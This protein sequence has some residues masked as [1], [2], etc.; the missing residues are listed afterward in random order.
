LDDR[1]D[2]NDFLRA[3]GERNHP[4]NRPQMRVKLF[5]HGSHLFATS[6]GMPPAIFISSKGCA[7]TFTTPAAYHLDRRQLVICWALKA[8]FRSVLIRIK[9]VLRARPIIP[10]TAK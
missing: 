7:V 9:A 2:G 4:P 5:H 6:K 1:Y 8:P 3:D 10:S